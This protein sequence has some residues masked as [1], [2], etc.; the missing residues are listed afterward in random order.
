MVLPMATNRIGLISDIHASPGVLAEAL[1]LFQQHEV[2]KILCAGDIAGYFDSV[3]ETV[4]LLQ[5]AN[6]ASVIGNHDLSYL[7]SHDTEPEVCDYLAELPRYR[8][9]DIAGNHIYLV[10]AEPPDELHGGIKLLDQ[11]GDLITQRLQQWQ[12][13]LAGFDAD[14]LVV[15]HTHQVYAVTLGEL[16]VVNPGS[17]PFN[18]SCMILDLADKSVRSYAVGAQEIVPCWNF[19]MQFGGRQAY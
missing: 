15:G 9:F 1:A 13:K 10:H 8:E 18:N 6:C 3:A 4:A 14:I 19:S 2:E 17:L 7:S 11:S 16:L 5:A 12:E